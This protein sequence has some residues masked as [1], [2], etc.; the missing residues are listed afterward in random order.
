MNTL[1]KN[2]RV[3]SCSPRVNLISAD[4]PRAGFQ[5]DCHSERSE[6]SSAIPPQVL[7]QSNWIL[8]CAQNDRRANSNSKTFP[9]DSSSE[10][11]VFCVVRGELS[12]PIGTR[13]AN[14]H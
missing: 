11:R 12:E 8:R 9:R 3:E 10:V 13:P 4:C 7:A 5:N 1:R 2:Q 6:E 14:R